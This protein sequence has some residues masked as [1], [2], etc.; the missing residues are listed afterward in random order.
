MVLLVQV[1]HEFID[2]QER[3]THASNTFHWTTEDPFSIPDLMQAHVDLFNVL[4]TGQFDELG[5]Y[6]SPALSRVSNASE[7]RVYDLDQPEPRLPIGNQFFTLPTSNDS[8]RYVAEVAAVG[9]IRATPIAGVNPQRLRGR[10]YFGPLN[11]GGIASGDAVIH[12]NLMDTIVNGLAVFRDAPPAN[13]L[14]VIYSAS[15]RDNTD[16]TIPY[17]DRPLLPPI[18]SAVVTIECDNG[19]DTQRRRGRAATSS[20]TA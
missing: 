15:A 20:V 7:V 5:A 9:S 14:W 10:K 3:G 2:A 17:E 16:D 13:C 6:L 4:A 18:S 8:F 11:G 1:S 12:P 19:P